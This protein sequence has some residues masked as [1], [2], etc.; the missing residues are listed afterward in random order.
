M[1][2]STKTHHRSVAC[3]VGHCDDGGE[4]SNMKIDL[5]K[6]LFDKDKHAAGFLANRRMP[7]FGCQHFHEEFPGALPAAGDGFRH[8]T[9]D[10]D[11]E[12]GSVAFH[13]P[14]YLVVPLRI[15]P[16]LVD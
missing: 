3:Q 16:R 12:A 1:E 7:F 11:G 2:C 13:K 5:E 15:A 6:E 9:Q 14:C 8:L 10:A 4:M